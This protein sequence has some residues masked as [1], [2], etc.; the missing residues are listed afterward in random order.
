MCYNNFIN[1]MEDYPR[2]MGGYIIMTVVE[3]LSGFKPH[4]LLKELQI[5]S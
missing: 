2:W 5:I 1:D 4:L 3:R